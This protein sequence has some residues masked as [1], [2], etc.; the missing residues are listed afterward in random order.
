MATPDLNFVWLTTI[1]NYNLLAILDVTRDIERELNISPDHIVIPVWQ[2]VIKFIQ[3]FPG[4]DSVGMRDRYCDTRHK[5]VAFLER[6]GLIT[7]HQV[8][9]ERIRWESRIQ[10]WLS[11]TTFRVF[12]ARINE[13]YGRRKRIE[14][15]VGTEAQPND[16]MPQLRLVLSRFHAVVI[17]LRRRHESRSTLEVVDEYDVQDLLRGLLTL[18]FDDIRP[19]EWTPSYAGKSARVD[20]FLKQEGILVEVKKTRPGL[21]E[22]SIGDQ[23]IIDIDRYRR[24]AECKS[25]VCF[26]Y[27]PD[28]RIS[29]PA[30]LQ[31]DLSRSEDGFSVEVFV[32]PM[33]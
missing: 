16:A 29:N 1:D 14:K 3:L 23:L 30:G 10:V 22:K 12:V 31:T 18:F 9:S 7:R 13:E 28:H 8:Y 11:E 24:M 33:R 27:D 32:F 4:P 20:F 6:H 26:V 17:E 21:N 19:E 2:S 15:Q 25:L 5:A